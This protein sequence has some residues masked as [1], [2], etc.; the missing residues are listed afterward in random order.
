MK[1][2]DP[3]TTHTLTHNEREGKTGGETERE[4]Q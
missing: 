1:E 4:P 3:A 2:K